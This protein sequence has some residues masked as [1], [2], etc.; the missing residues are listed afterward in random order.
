M[1]HIYI[2]IIIIIFLLWTK[3]SEG[4][5][6]P[7]CNTRVPKYK[8]G[9]EGTYEYS[10]IGNSFDCYNKCVK[11]A[12]CGYVGVGFD[13]YDNCFNNFLPQDDDPLVPTPPTT[14]DKF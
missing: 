2:I 6:N 8:Q 14:I 12:E 13:C 5:D 3:S 4:Y 10:V 9:C 11:G 1:N 7:R